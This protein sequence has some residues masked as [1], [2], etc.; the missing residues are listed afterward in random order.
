M[1]ARILDEEKSKLIKEVN[2]NLSKKVYD[3]KIQD[4]VNYSSLQLLFNESRNKNKKLD[5]ISK[6]KLKDTLVNRLCEQKQVQEQVKLKP[7][8]DNTVYRVLVKKFNEKYSGKLTEAQ[9]KFLMQYTLS[10]LSEDKKQFNDFLL[11]EGKKILVSL[12]NIKDKKILEDKELMHKIN[13]CKE[14]YKKEVLVSKD[15]EKIVLGM[16]QYV[17]LVEELVNE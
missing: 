6:I 2:Y 13:E 9:K 3:Y 4:Y 11:N 16:M 17:A 5:E 15:K 10:M 12:T 7:E 1:N 8:I 14:K